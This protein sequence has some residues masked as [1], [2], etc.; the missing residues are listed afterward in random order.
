MPVEGA[1]VRLL[2]EDAVAAG[3]SPCTG[4]AHPNATAALVAWS[5]GAP[6]IAVQKTGRKPVPSGTQRLVGTASPVALPLPFGPSMGN[7]RVLWEDGEEGPKTGSEPCGEGHRGGPSAPALMNS[8]PIPRP[9]GGSP[10]PPSLRSSGK[11]LPAKVDPL[12]RTI[13]SKVRWT[14]AEYQELRR[15][16]ASARLDMSGYVRQCSLGRAPVTIPPVNAYAAAELARIGN[17]VSQIARRLRER[18]EPSLDELAL[19]YTEVVEA[20]REIHGRLIGKGRA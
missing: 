19:A 10:I 16:A 8:R 2:S 18:E 11:G 17:N 20:I 14:A 1:T 15:R 9:A 5:A 12:R 7:Q 3:A 6:H 4:A 13:T